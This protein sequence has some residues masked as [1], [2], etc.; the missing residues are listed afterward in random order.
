MRLFCPKRDIRV[1]LGPWS[2]Q[3]IVSMCQY[4]LKVG[5]SG[6]FSWIN[7]YRRPLFLIKC[8]HRGLSGIFSVIITGYSRRGNH[9][10][11]L[12][13]R[14][15]VGAKRG[16]C[17][18]AGPFTCTPLRTGHTRFRVPSSPL[19]IMMTGDVTPFAES[20]PAGRVHR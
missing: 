17:L 19:L 2:S 12:C 16:T 15:R 1:V 14:S 5:L 9:S 11:R 18:S 4:P 7:P 3:K 20:H 6:I 13:S 10:P 8:C